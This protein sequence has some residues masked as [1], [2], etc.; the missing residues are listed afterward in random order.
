MFHNK[1][2][3]ALCAVFLFSAL[4]AIADTLTIERVSQLN[5][6]DRML[7]EAYLKQS[8]EK[9]K[10]DAISVQREVDEN[11]MT[12]ALRAPSG[13][14]FK[15][16]HQAGDIWFAGE[17]A[18]QLADSI[19]SYQTPSGGWSKHIGFSKGPRQTGMQWTSQ[20]EPGQPSHYVATFDNNSTTSEMQFLANVWLATKRE[21]CQAGFVKGLNFIFDAQFPNGGWPQV[22]PLEGGYH[23][24]ITFN[25]DSMTHILELLYA[26]T[27]NDPC[28]AFVGELQRKQA[29]AALAAGI[30]CLLQLQIEQHGK[31]TAWCAQYDPLTLKPAE[32]RK[33]EPVAICGLESANILR[34]LMTIH[35]PPSDVVACIEAGLQWLDEAKVIG[36]SKAKVN[37]KTSYVPDPTSEQVY[38]ARFY[39]LAT[40]RPIFPGRDG[41]LYD[42][43]NAMAAKNDLGYD[44]YTSRPESILRNGQKKWRK[45]LMIRAE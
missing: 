23:D 19:L 14:D 29:A 20:S 10:V 22:F 35:E 36:L 9:A 3:C 17:E 4:P 2:N 40:G 33:M 24:N 11:K 37:G 30:D 45:R 32:A 38:W 12:S 15:L 7:W 27:R 1:T 42:T 43:F 13:G 34:F 31:K 26:V 44:Y 5:P 39:D 28:Y 41:V 8:S 25:D 21:D 6:T 16:K 18:K